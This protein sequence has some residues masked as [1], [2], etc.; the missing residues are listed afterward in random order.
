M[1]C[2]SL[3]T[4]LDNELNPFSRLVM[5]AHVTMCAECRRNARAWSRLSPQR[6]GLEDRPMPPT[7]VEKL[8]EDAASAAAIARTEFTPRSQRSRLQ[9]VL[10]MKRRLIAVGL[11]GIIALVAG[12]LSPKADPA[13]AAV[14][15]AM[16]SIRNVHVTGWVVQGG[17]RRELEVWKAGTS[18]MR[19]NIEGAPDQVVDGK[20]LVEISQDSVVIKSSG[21]ILGPEGTNAMEWLSGDFWQGVANRSKHPGSVKKSDGVLPGGRPALVLTLEIGGD[22]M[23]IAIAKDTNLVARV[24]DYDS[25]NELTLDMQHIEYNVDI[26]AEVFDPKYPASAQVID[27]LNPKTSDRYPNGKSCGLESALESLSENDRVAFRGL[28][29]NCDEVAELIIKGV[30]KM[31]EME[32]RPNHRASRSWKLAKPIALHIAKTHAL[33]PGSELTVGWLGDPNAGA[34][35]QRMD[36]EISLTDQGQIGYRIPLA[37]TDNGAR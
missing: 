11:V 26:P 18:R 13:L 30:Q 25:K 15:Q 21:N 29:S 1:R 31:D 28:A 9:G 35:T 6:K 12:A 16:S 24:Q 36:L 17:E 20:R 8:L 10:T 7:L 5:R 14:V 4:Y 19:T 37:E 2:D 23:V 22:K 27:M 34:R 3:K 32:N 33:P